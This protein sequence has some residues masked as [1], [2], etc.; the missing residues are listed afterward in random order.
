MDGKTGLN[1]R[2]FP[3][4]AGKAAIG[5]GAAGGALGSPASAQEKFPARDVSWIIYQAPG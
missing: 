3:A 2:A 5:V 4:H 1:R